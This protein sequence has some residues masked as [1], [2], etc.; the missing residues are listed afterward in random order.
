M[1]F[2]N[3]DIAKFIDD[4]FEPA[5]QTVAPVPV[6]TI[7]FGNG[8]KI[9]RT[10]RGNIASYVVSP[11]G[12]VLDIMPGLIQPATYKELLKQ[13]LTLYRQIEASPSEKLTQI[14][15]YHQKAI[16][17]GTLSPNQIKQEA[18]VS[19]SVAV[20]AKLLLSDTLLN[21][22]QAHR[23]IHKKLASETNLTLAELTKWVYEDVLDVTLSDPYLGFGKLLRDET[24]NKSKRKTYINDQT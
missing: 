11:D 2:G 5:W 7:D 19:D 20:N 10:F 24:V 12:T 9:K 15:D 18:L 23:V 4:N 8:N 1:L 22:L 21:E 6:V 14:S 3:N 17:S 13:T 16:K